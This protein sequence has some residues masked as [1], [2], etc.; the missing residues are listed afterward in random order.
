MNYTGSATTNGTEQER[1]LAQDSKLAQ[2]V[3]RAT[4][5]A[6]EKIDAATDAARP[7]VDR[8]VKGAHSTVDSIGNMATHAAETLD[9]KGE[10][11]NKAR[12]QLVKATGD[13][14]HAHPIA[15]IAM[16][17]AAGYLLSRVVAQR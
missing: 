8:M 1:K 13:Y 2:G 4:A 5:G 3:D 17:I 7:A 10:Q 9:V 14:L 6:H 12:S 11:L 15:S 16:A